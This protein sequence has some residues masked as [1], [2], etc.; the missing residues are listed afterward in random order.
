MVALVLT[1]PPLDGLFPA[2]AEAG[3]AGLHTQARG[4]KAKWERHSD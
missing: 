4:R 2:R 3:V 1:P